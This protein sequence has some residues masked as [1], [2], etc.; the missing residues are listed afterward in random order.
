MDLDLDLT[1]TCTR[2]HGQIPLCGSTKRDW[3]LFLKK[4]YFQIK[5]VRKIEEH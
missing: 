5:K 4:F 1:V 3:I 2:R